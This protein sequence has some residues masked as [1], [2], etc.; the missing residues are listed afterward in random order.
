MADVCFVCVYLR[1]MSLF[2]RCNGVYRRH[3]GTN[4]PSRYGQAHSGQRSL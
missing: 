4:P 2:V 1:D 3:F